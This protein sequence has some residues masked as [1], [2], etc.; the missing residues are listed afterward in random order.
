M[1]AGSLGRLLKRHLELLIIYAHS[2]Y[3]FVQR[4]WG[5]STK[6]V[7]SNPLHVGSTLNTRRIGAKHGA[8]EIQHHIVLLLIDIPGFYCRKNRSL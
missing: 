4:T 2:F 6:N 8:T 7:L 1:G 3:G 5:F